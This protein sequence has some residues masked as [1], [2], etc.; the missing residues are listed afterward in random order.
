M[1]VNRAHDWEI[2]IF[3]ISIIRELR[4]RSTRLEKRGTR[5]LATRSWPLGWT[6]RLFRNFFPKKPPER[7]CT[8]ISRNETNLLKLSG[9]EN[10]P[11]FERLKII[12][13][14][15][16]FVVTRCTYLMRYINRILSNSKFK[17]QTDKS[18]NTLFTIYPVNRRQNDF[19]PCAKKFISIISS[20]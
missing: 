11:Q 17:F 9:F 19:C 20:V 1:Y 6:A 4:L 12:T 14:R 16:N 5:F 8:V 2:I 3:S 15:H 7:F 13:Y 18:K 10:C